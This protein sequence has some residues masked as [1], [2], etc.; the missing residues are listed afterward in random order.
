VGPVTEQSEHLSSAQIENYGNRTSGA[1]PDTAQG[2]ERQRVDHQSNDDLSMNDQRVEAHLADCPSCRNRVLDFHRRSFALLAQPERAGSASSNPGLANSRLADERPTDSALADSKFANSKYPV[3]AQVRTAPTPECPSSDALRQFAAGLTPDALAAKLTQHAATCDHCGPLLRTFTEDF[4]DD[5]TPEEQSALANLK[6]SS[7]KWQK[8]TARK[9]L[10]VGGMKTSVEPKPFFW[11]WV[12]IPATAAVVAV[13][14]ITFPIYYA[15]ATPEKAEAL[16]AQSYTEQRTMEM[17][18]PGAKWGPVRT[19]R[20]PEESRFGRPKSLLK[21]EGIIGDHDPSNPANITWLRAKAQADILDRNPEAA[22]AGLNKALEVQPDSVP[23]MVD[24]GIAYDLQAEVSGDPRNLEQ[25]IDFLG[26]ALKKEPSNREALF[27]RALLY[28]RTGFIDS[29]IAD[30]DTLLKNE[31]DPLWKDEAQKK[32]DAL[33]EL[34]RKQS[35]IALPQSLNDW[36]VVL[37]SGDPNGV[38]SAL[39]SAVLEWLSPVNGFSAQAAPASAELLT[40]AA[41]KIESQHQDQWLTDL[42]RTRD[43]P[44]FDMAI[45]ALLSAVLLNLE[46]KASDAIIPA[47]QAQAY[48]LRDHNLPGLARAQ[49]EEIYAY[50]RS[51]D[52]SRCLNAAVPLRQQIETAG[53]TWI[54]TQLLLD[55]ASCFNILGRLEEAKLDADDALALAKKSNY[56]ILSLRA[57]AIGASLATTRGDS[58]FA[59]KRDMEG[60]QEYW[61][62]QYPI[63]RA[64]QFYSDLSFNAEAAELWHL[65]YAA[66]EQAVWAI[67][68]TPKKRVE[69]IARYRLAK[70]AVM[71]GKS[72]SAASE[73]DEAEKL[74]AQPPLSESNA[75]AQLDGIIGVIRA[76]INLG[77]YDAASARLKQVKIPSTFTDSRLIARRLDQVR[78]DIAFKLG[79]LKEA[80]EAYVAA[81]SIAESSLSTLKDARDRM[82][83]NQENGPS[84]RALADVAQKQ[85]DPIAALEIWELY[86]AAAIRQKEPLRSLALEIRPNHAL[87]DLSISGIVNQVRPE[88][89]DETLISYAFLPTGLGIW[90]LTD[91]EFQFNIAE[92]NPTEIERLARQFAEE[93]ANPQSNLEE[94]RHNGNLL[95]KILIPPISRHLKLGH[96]LTLEMDGELDGLPFSALVDESGKYLI[97]SHPV[98]LSSGL[99]YR[100]YLRQSSPIRQNDRALVVGNPA[101]SPKWRRLLPPLVSANQEAIAVASGF[102]DA[103]ILLGSNATKQRVIDKLIGAKVLH[104]ASHSLQTRLGPALVLGDSGTGNDL[105]AIADLPAESLQQANLIVLSACGTQSH[106]TRMESYSRPLISSRVPH[107]LATLWQV[108][109]A[110]TLTFMVEFYH[111]LWDAR[112]PVDSVAAAVHLIQHQKPYSHPYFWA[113]FV[114]N[115]Q[116]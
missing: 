106:Q 107:V 90:V 91:T 72:K 94:L 11:K 12:L 35:S 115:G 109:S 51:P 49:L 18:W 43:S 33:K 48:F 13:A 58:S 86:R 46:D 101:V 83:W 105:L 36:N 88:L 29:A 85:G 116:R 96:V 61:A 45:S 104:F 102:P 38:E 50:Q 7:T 66:D 39:D 92:T 44:H 9:M 69:G 82:I 74:F 111:R 76:E 78:G 25:A 98:L 59:V 2:D 112:R 99:S 108:D 14:A 100:H 73:M 37:G 17:R 20:G 27:N 97:E 95:Y 8:N 54:Q 16:L 41:Q 68:Q 62:G 53:Y 113:S 75:V 32:L 40:T 5:F 60:L 67:S 71:I 65:A 34:K 93:C 103:A 57:L 42:L 4:S 30:W 87:S 80:Q 26:K 110:A 64:Y 70:A 22:I 77:S 23:L 114:L 1:G 6:S 31:T 52:G 84:Y 21:A 55:E 47:R 63:V 89:R 24:L 28:G 79:R 10:E 15:R 19:T 81:V 56:R 3:Q